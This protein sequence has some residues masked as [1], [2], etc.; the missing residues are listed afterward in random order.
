M[1]QCGIYD[2]K[3]PLME[4]SFYAGTRK[5]AAQMVR[6]FKEKQDEIYQAILYAMTPSDEKESQEE[7]E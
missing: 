1:V 4:L 7:D 3:T 5:M 6:H 2:N